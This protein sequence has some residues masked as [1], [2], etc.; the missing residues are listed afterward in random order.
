MNIFDLLKLER[1]KKDLFTF[2]FKQKYNHEYVEWDP[3][4]KFLAGALEEYLGNIDVYYEI[5]TNSVHVVLSS[6]GMRIEAEGK[7]DDENRLFTFYLDF[8]G[9][10]TDHEDTV[11]W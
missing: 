5:K 6:Q 1:Y 7:G 10:I 3:R 9:N 2:I 4:Y 11:S 8:A